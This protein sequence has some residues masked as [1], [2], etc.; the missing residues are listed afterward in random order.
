MWYWYIQCVLSVGKV[1]MCDLFLQQVFRTTIDRECKLRQSCSFPHTRVFTF[2]VLSFIHIPNKNKF[3]AV[4]F[5]I[6]FVCV[7]QSVVTLSCLSQTLLTYNHPSFIEYSYNKSV[8]LA[9]NHKYLVFISL[10][11]SCNFSYCKLATQFPQ[12]F[13][14]LLTCLLKL[15]LAIKNDTQSYFPPCQISQEQAIFVHVVQCC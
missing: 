4:L 7:W 10:Q 11:I 8:K 9:S 3:F 5:D 12:F 15:N 1:C 14:Q 6:T 13:K 2:S